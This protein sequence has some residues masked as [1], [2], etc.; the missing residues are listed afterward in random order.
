MKERLKNLEKLS[1]PISLGIMAFAITGAF[2]RK[3]RRKIWERDKG[4][5]SICGSTDNLQCA[6]IDHNKSNPRYNDPSN[7]RLL[8]KIPCHLNDHINREGRN[9]LSKR[10][11]QWSINA[12]KGKFDK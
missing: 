3:V 6:H 1:I 2:S 12:L 9:G 5:C 8:C 10:Q 11:N 7:G 4:T